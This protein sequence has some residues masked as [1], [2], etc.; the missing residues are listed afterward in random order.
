MNNR[1]DAR[2]EFSFRG[3]TYSP[4]ANI[5]LDEL[6]AGSETYHGLHLRLARANGINSSVK[7]LAD[8]G[9]EAI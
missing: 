8:T 1:I 9:S 5:D 7:Q 6:M 2:I 4:S 3:E